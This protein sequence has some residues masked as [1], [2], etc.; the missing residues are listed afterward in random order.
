MEAV[1]MVVAFME[2]APTVVA[3]TGERMCTSE[4]IS[5]FKNGEEHH[6]AE[7]FDSCSI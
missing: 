2:A 1:S 5:E 3:G 4:S 7:N 6:A